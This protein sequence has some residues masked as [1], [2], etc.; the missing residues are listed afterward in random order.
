VGG[1]E[2]LPLGGIA[3]IAAQAAGGVALNRKPFPPQ[4]KAIDIGSYYTDSSR[5]A[6][7]LGWKPGVRFEEG[8]A[9]TLGY[10]RQHLAHYLDPA[11][12]HPACSMPEHS[13]KRGRLSYAH[14]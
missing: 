14:S 1:P 10:Y 4:A 7:E 13:G 12:P 3:E 11:N 9:R 5:I 6:R 2:P 8:I